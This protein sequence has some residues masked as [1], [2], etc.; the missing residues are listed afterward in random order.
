MADAHDLTRAQ[1]EGLHDG[2]PTADL[3]ADTGFVISRVGETYEDRFQDLGIDYY[4]YRPF[5]GGHRGSA[6]P[7]LG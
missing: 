3:P 6:A 1:Y 7:P 5:A 2:Q 4:D